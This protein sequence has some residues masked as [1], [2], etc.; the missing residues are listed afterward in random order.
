MCPAVISDPNRSAPTGHIGIGAIKLPVPLHYLV[1]LPFAAYV[2]LLRGTRIHDAVQ[3]DHL[4]IRF[5]IAFI[6]L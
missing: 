5:N 4:S 2:E 6:A 3:H 1:F